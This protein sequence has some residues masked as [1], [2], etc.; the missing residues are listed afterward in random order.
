[1]LVSVPLDPSVELRR[2]HRTGDEVTLELVAAERGE[3]LLDLLR[4]HAL[5]DHRGL[6]VVREIDGFVTMAQSACQS[7]MPSTNPRSILI[8]EIG[9]CSAHV[10]LVGTTQTSTSCLLIADCS[11]ASRSRRKAST[12]Y[13]TSVMAD[14]YHECRRQAR[15]T[16]WPFGHRPMPEGRPGDGRLI[17]RVPLVKPG[18]EIDAKE[19][20]PE[21]KRCRYLVL[22]IH[23]DRPDQLGTKEGAHT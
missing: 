18:R 23:D 22:G 8:S 3:S 17:G 1:V 21:L 12:S 5:G 19:P 7:R 2:R 20:S 4:L 16:G 11:L 15:E 13:P 10:R 14:G 9:S 6:E